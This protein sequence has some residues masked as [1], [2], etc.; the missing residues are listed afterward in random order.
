MPNINPFLRH[1]LRFEAG[2]ENKNKSTDALF[3][4]ARLQGF[5]NDPD[6]RGGA[7]MIGVTLAA[8]TAWRKS[9][10]RPAPT[11]KDLKAISYEEWRSIADNDFWQGRR[12]EISIRGNDGRRL[13]IPQRSTWDQS[14]STG[15]GCDCRRNYGGEDFG[16]GQCNTARDAVSCTQKRAA[17]I[18]ACHSEE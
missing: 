14:S 3:E 8:F 11:V 6:D 18:F 12:I 13:Y 1:L 16:R 15:T 4:K 17:E 2:V 10:K 9:Q 7:T 5:A